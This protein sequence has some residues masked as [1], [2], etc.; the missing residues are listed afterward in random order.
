MKTNVAVKWHQTEI[1][2][3]EETILGASIV[4]RKISDEKGRGVFAMRDI[5]EGEVIEISPVVPVAKGNVIENGDAPDGYLL[6]WDADTEGEEYAM[7]LGYVMLYNHNPEPNILI[8]SDMAEYTMTVKAS[9]NIKAGEE[10]TWNYAC[11]LWF[12][13]A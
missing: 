3:R 4:W 13:N 7:P 6:Q 10:L 11:E 12:D 8:E 5:L 9:R 1:A 2:N